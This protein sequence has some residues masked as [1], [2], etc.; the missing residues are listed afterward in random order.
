M[1]QVKNLFSNYG[2]S[3]LHD[4]EDSGY[5]TPNLTKKQSEKSSPGTNSGASSSSSQ[6]SPENLASTA[7]R[8]ISSNNNI[9]G[10][11]HYG[12][13]EYLSPKEFLNTKTGS[14]F[15]FRK[16]SSFGKSFGLKEL[17]DSIRIEI[18]P[19]EEEAEKG[20]QNATENAINGMHNE[21]ENVINGM[22]NETEN[23]INRMQKSGLQLQVR[24]ILSYNN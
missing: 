4:R 7:T 22:Q 24:V 20:M 9:L 15:S 3:G 1:S 23:T 11:G 8:K 21:N 5:M 16:Y 10:N 18:S 19:P 14:R 12:V 2:F 6:N 13:K 17:A